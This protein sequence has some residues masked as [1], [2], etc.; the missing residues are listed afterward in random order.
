MLDD[1]ERTVLEETERALARDDPSWRGGCAG[2]VSAVDG[3]RAGE[4]PSRS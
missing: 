2:P 3:R 1:D 4:P